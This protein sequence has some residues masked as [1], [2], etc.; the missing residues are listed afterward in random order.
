MLE[1]NNPTKSMTILKLN[2]SQQI[3]TNA[4]KKDTKM[5]EGEDGLSEKNNQIRSTESLHFFKNDFGRSDNF[6]RMN[7]SLSKI[8]DLREVKGSRNETKISNRSD[9][10]EALRLTESLSLLKSNELLRT[11]GDK[12]DFDKKILPDDLR[13]NRSSGINNNNTNNNN[14]NSV[15]NNSNSA[16]VQG[17]GSQQSRNNISFSVASLLADTRPRRS[18]SVL[19]SESPSPPVCLYLIFYFIYYK[20]ITIVEYSRKNSKNTKLVR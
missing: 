13:T 4:V 7:E 6:L 8:S 19:H 12:K 3:K 16:P 14:N 10:S 9:V 2:P 20:Y 5:D 1:Q 17:S 11:K 15:N 18:P